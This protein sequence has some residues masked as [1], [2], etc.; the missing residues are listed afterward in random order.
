MPAAAAPG[1]DTARATQATQLSCALCGHSFT[2]GFLRTAGGEASFRPG[3]V[4]VIVIGHAAGIS[5]VVHACRPVVGFATALAAIRT[6]CTPGRMGPQR[7][8]MPGCHALRAAKSS[9]NAQSALPPCANGLL[10]GLRCSLLRRTF[11][12]SCLRPSQPR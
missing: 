7:G 1:C 5:V 4:Y 2:Q 3:L 8:H 9:R 12:G 11:S 10:L 6:P